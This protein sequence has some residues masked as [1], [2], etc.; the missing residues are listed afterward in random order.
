MGGP[1][2]PRSQ[3]RVMLRLALVG[4]GCAVHL[5]SEKT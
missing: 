1:L 5:I 3:P 2:L 4:Q